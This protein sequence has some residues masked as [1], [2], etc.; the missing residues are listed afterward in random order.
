MRDLSLTTRGVIEALTGFREPT[1][2]E[3]EAAQHFDTL[4]RLAP[5][6]SRSTPVSQ[7]R[8]ALAR[9][10]RDLQLFASLLEPEEH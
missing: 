10:I 3:S 4:H 9:R 2:G 6:I 1:I 7:A 5:E 8:L